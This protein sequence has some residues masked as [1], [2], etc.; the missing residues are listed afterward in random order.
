MRYEPTPE[1][2]TI[3]REHGV[4][5]MFGSL[6]VSKPNH[7]GGVNVYLDVRNFSNKIV[8]Y[9]TFELEAYNKVGDVVT[10]EIGHRSTERVQA[11]GPFMPN[12]NAMGTW[13]NVWYNS[14]ISCVKMK[15]V[16]IQYIDNVTITLNK[17][18]IN[19]A[20]GKGMKNDCSFK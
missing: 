11:T 19:Y 1:E 20:F 5:I 3:A 6:D 13:E 9:Y 7:V 14:T 18:K 4:P 17:D 8:K 12:K 16:S 15:S 2:I 10:S